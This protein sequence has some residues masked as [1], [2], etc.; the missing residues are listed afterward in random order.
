MSISRYTLLVLVISAFFFIFPFFW[1]R[2][3]EMDLGGDSSRLYFYD[4]LRYLFSQSLFSVS[5]SAFGGESLSF[6]GIPFFLFLFLFKSILHSPTTLISAF[7]GFSLS[8]A[9]LSCYLIVKELLKGEK[10]ATG[11]NRII[12]EAASVLAGF[13]YTLSPIPILWWGYPILTFNQV[14]ISPLMFFLLLRFFLTQNMRYMI[15]ALL[16]S[17]LFAPNFSY[18]GA[19]TFFAFYPLAIAFL[20]SY[21]K[22]VRHRSIPVKK[23]AVGVLLFVLIH[24]FHLIPQLVN[25]FTPGS[26]TYE[27]VFGN[28]GKVG[29]LGYFS[30]IAPSIKVSYHL[31]GLQQLTKHEFLS[32]IFIIFPFIFTLGF[33]WNKS[34][35]YLLTGIFFLITLFFVSAN[36]TNIGF[37]LYALAFQFP[38]FSMFRN[39]YGQWQWAYLFFYALLFGQALFIIMVHIKKRQRFVLVGFLVILFL[40]TS[41]PFINGTITDTTLWQSKDIKSHVVMDPKYEGVLSYIRSLPVDG[42]V[43]SFPLDDHGYQVIKGRN[44]AAYVGP[45]TIT[46][47][48]NKNEFKGFDEF[49]EFGPN[50]L[51]AARDKNYEALRDMLA[52]FNIKYIFYNSDPY[53]YGDNFPGLPYRHVPKFLPPDQKEYKKFIKNLGVKEIKTI[54]GKYHIYEVDNSTYLPHIYAAKR[55]AYWNGD[56][57]DLHAPLS[58]YLK[59]KR[60]AFYNISNIKI[61]NINKDIF[62]NIFIKAQNKSQIFDFFKIKDFPKFVSP[63]ISQKLSSFVYPLVVLREKMDIGRLPK[64]TDEHIDRSIYFAEKRINELVELEDIPILKNVRSIVNLA[65]IWQEPKLWEFVRYGEYNS[66]EI[67]L[68]RYY[69]A[70][71]GLIKELDK[72]NQSYYSNVTNK[73]ELKK[74]VGEHETKLR[75]AIR[76]DS[77]KSIEEKKYIFNLARDMFAD[78]LIKLNLDLPDDWIIPYDIGN[79]LEDGTYQVYVNK[80]DVKNLDITLNIDGKNISPKTLDEG[81]WIRFDDILVK[82]K[83]S[84]PV[85]INMNKIPNLVSE[86]RWKTAEQTKGEIVTQARSDEAKQKDKGDLTTLTITYSYLGNTSGLIRD[87]SQWKGNSIYVIS[88]DYLTYDQNFLFT[89]YERGGTKKDRYVNDTYSERLRSKKWK[90]FSSAFIALQDAKSAFLQISKDQNDIQDETYTEGTKKIDIKNLSVLRITDFQI[91]DPR[92]VFKKVIKAEE[93]STPQII[94]TKINPT[95]YKVAVAGAKDAYALVLS[96][97]FNTSWKI[98]FPNK[99]NEAK[100]LK[101]LISRTLGKIM[102]GI[103]TANNIVISSDQSKEELTSYFNNKIIEGMHKNIFLDQNTFETFGYDPIAEKTHLPVNGY[104]NAWYITANDVQNKKDYTLIIEMTTQKLFYGSLLVSLGGLSLLSFILFRSFIRK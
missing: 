23:L 78:I 73:V 81:E 92:I 43:L 29:R 77:S 26:S 62:D 10:E 8:L 36:I 60:L 47:L 67:T 7:H 21:I 80:D 25:L 97:K 20:L 27:T 46:Y 89:L 15:T 54:A 28:Q 30:A 55:T 104:A 93:T 79:Q 98:F 51:T 45:S 70:M 18:I 22:L 61:F 101:G 44:D 16:V 5:H 99:T 91:V 75:E 68:E 94:F 11:K 52:M 100:T 59:D 3:G 33:L 102:K 84:L 63:T 66:W 64:V 71:I 41:W 14:F 56:L 88:F 96:E 34:K 12:A 9:F 103:L 50:F 72:P 37:R 49:G 57:V 90:K 31:L 42:K 76:K 6:F 4:P 82:N 2:P 24:A 32:G 53:I 1:L 58:F 95:K 83:S 40:T 69:K 86:T 19:P 35:T 38:G 85:A 39:Y 65:G 48:T 74:V 13:F 17:V 87:I